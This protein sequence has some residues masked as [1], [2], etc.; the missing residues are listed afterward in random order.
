MLFVIPSISR[1][2]L[3]HYLGAMI[4]VI[5]FVMILSSS[6][7]GLFKG[8]RYLP[9]FCTKFILSYMADSLDDLWSNFSLSEREGGEIQINDEQYP[10]PANVIVGKFVLRRTIG[11]SELGVA[12]SRIWQLNSSLKVSALGEAM[13]VFEFG[14]TTECNRI[15]YKQPWN[16]NSALLIFSRLEGKERPTDLKLTMVPF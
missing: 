4:L 11:A 8:D 16:F 13:F 10:K 3:F 12:L 5:Y 15:L 2:F 1:D 14:S 7:L 6:I 9:L